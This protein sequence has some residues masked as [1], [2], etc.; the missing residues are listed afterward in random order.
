MCNNLLLRY[1]IRN[2]DM[3]LN[4]NVNKILTAST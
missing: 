3:A 1:Y 4:E 2:V